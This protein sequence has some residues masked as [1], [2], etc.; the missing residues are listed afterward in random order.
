MSAM[1]AR[2]CVCLVSPVVNVVGNGGNVESN[3]V[4]C[5]ERLRNEMVS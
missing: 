2:T 4:S 3:D 5:L 1:C